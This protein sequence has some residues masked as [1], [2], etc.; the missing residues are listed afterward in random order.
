MY[1][2]KNEVMSQSII[3]GKK[4][5]FFICLK[6]ICNKRIK[7]D[8]MMLIDFRRKLLSEEHLFKS[9]LTSILIQKHNKINSGQ[10]ISFSNFY[11]EL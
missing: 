10:N 1:L 7:R 9:H 6:I 11:N 4:F 2:I 8:M 5:S 3:L